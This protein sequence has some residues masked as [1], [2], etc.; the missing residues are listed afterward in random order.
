ML[1]ALL[2]ALGED[3]GGGTTRLRLVAF[4]FFFSTA[5]VKY[6]PLSF[7]LLNDTGFKPLAFPQDFTQHQPGNTGHL[8]AG[9]TGFCSPSKRSLPPAFS[10][11]RGWQ[12]W[13]P[14]P[15]VP[16][17]TV[18]G[19]T[20]GPNPPP[21]TP[22]P[23]PASPPLRKKKARPSRHLENNVTQPEPRTDLA[24]PSCHPGSPAPGQRAHPVPRPRPRDP[25]AGSPPRARVASVAG[26]G[27]TRRVSAPAPPP[28]DTRPVPL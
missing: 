27:R 3:G 14:R 21:P 11:R 13:A 22:P 26:G 25:C 5:G 2:H 15:F 16:P 28:Q 18:P 9:V 24:A 12:T 17:Q 7:K 6:N 8:G 4:F 20:A 1:K 19:L 23:R 10:G